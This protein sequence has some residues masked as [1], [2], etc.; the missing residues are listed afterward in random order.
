MQHYTQLTPAQCARRGPAVM[1][2]TGDAILFWS[3]TLT[4]VE[5]EASMHASCPVI[6]GEKW[7]ATKWCVRCAR[8]ITFRKMLATLSDSC[9]CTTRL[10]TEVFKA[11]DGAASAPNTCVDK[12]DLCAGVRTLRA[13]APHVL[14]MRAERCL[15]CVRV[16]QQWATN[17]QCEE[18]AKFMLGA[19]G[20]D[21]ACVRSCCVPHVLHGVAPEECAVCDGESMR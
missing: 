11:G 20:R 14:C 1:P 19:F 4:G 7:T 21:G 9:V 13:S 16:A 17:N 12:Q 5:D 15:A 6:R 2:R 18:N 3:M 8:S 10:H